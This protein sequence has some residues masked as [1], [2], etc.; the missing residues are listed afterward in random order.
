M[1]IASSF[2]QNDATQLQEVIRQYPFASLITHSESGIEVNHIPF[3]LDNSTGECVLQGHIAKANPLWKNVK[4]SA[5]VLLVFHGPNCYISPNYY[6]TKKQHGRAVPT[7]NYIAVHVKGTLLIRFDDQFKL[8]MLNNLTVQHEQNQA[9]PWSINDAP[10][11]YIER[12]LTAI[13]GLE[14]HITSITGQ[15]K[16]S[17]NQPEVNK[18]GV[19]DGLSK[20][21]TSDALK[22]AA[23]VK[24]HVAEI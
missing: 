17:Q 1:H 12:M 3:F 21:Q 22:I 4:D 23:L 2:Q 7:W 6:P 13:V 16:V 10:E 9:T 5:E 24:M 15:W 8:D 11:Q 19:I 20:A 18:Q 14:I